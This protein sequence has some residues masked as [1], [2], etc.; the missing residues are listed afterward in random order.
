VHWNDAATVIGEQ[1]VPDENLLWSGQPKGGVRFRPS[2][3]FLVPASLMWGGF[4]FFWETMVLTTDAPIFLKLWGVP[5]VLVGIH[6][7]AGRFFWDAHRRARTFYGV[8]DRRIVIVRTGL[9]ARVQSLQMRTLADVTLTASRDGTGTITFGPTPA[10][11]WFAGTG[12][13]GAHV[14]VPQFEWV[15]E[16]KATYDLI[17]EAQRQAAAI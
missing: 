15:E 3:L 6:L 10:G 7:I 4:A 5:F 2:D 1:L 16:A 13:P 9:G 11:A 8:T 17:G 14:Q 12:W